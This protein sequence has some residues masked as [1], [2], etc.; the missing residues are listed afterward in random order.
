MKYLIF[1]D[2][3]GSAET[4]EQILNI[5]KEKKCDQMIILGD[6]IYHG[7]RNPLTQQYNSMKVAE[8]LNAYKDKIIGVRGNCDSEVDQMVLDFPCGNDYALICDNGVNIFATH[9][10]IYGPSNLPTFTSID[11]LLYGHTH[12]YEISKKDD[13]ILCNPGSITLPRGGNPPTYAI[14]ENR[15][16][17]IYDFN[18][19]EALKSITI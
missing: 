13:T 17:T 10:H 9:G 5:F 1:S 16:L 7:P 6:Y 3:H 11:L 4:T 2:I 19:D 12:V 14:Y 18:T 8:L 15:N